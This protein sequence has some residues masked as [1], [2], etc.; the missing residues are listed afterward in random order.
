MVLLTGILG[1]RGEE[2][3]FTELN[4]LLTST[5]RGWLTWNIGDHQ[6]GREAD[7]TGD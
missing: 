1:I 5:G 7:G 3:V 2:C 4:Q 6:F